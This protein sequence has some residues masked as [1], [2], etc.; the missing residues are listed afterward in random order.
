MKCNY[1]EKPAKYKCKNC[2]DVFCWDHSS[3]KNP[4]DSQ[5]S[6]ILLG[7]PGTKCPSC[8]KSNLQRVD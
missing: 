5:M 4:V 1:C 8:G 2:G 6:A 7:G 3:H